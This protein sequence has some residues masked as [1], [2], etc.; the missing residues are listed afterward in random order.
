LGCGFGG[1]SRETQV[2]LVSC[3][4]NIIFFKNIILNFFKRQIKFLPVIWLLLNFS[5]Q[6]VHIIITS[7]KFNLKL[8]IKKKSRVESFQV[9]PLD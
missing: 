7:T 2:D 6:L 3:R 9:D 5:S 1:L 8:G 4:L